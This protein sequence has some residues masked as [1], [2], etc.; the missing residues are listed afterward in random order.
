MQRLSWNEFQHVLCLGAHCDDIEIG[1]GGTILSMLRS[2][3]DLRV[4]WI[5]FSSDSVRQV[6]AKN[7]ASQFLANCTRSEVEIKQFPDRY[8]PSVWAEIK[9]Y[10]GQLASNF[11]GDNSPD[12]IF[13]H[14]RADRHQDHNL[15]GELT[16]NAFRNH[17]ILEYEIPKFE[18]D[19]GHPNIFVP[20]SD[21]IVESKI[22]ILS[23]CYPS[24]SS[25]HWFDDETFRSLMRIRGL[26]SGPNQYAEAFYAEKLVLGPL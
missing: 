11:S 5:V 2:N 20:L 14:R 6:E 21:E 17:V 24:Q 19:L 26:E 25:H 13:T 10:F 3:P 8:F 4:T 22:D 23:N 7:A 16:W 18:G 12:L 15:I 9:D 1:C